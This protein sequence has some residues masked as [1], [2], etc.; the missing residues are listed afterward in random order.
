MTQRIALVAANFRKEVTSTVMWLSQFRV[1]MQCFKATPFAL[2]DELFLNVEQIIP[3]KDAEDF[4]IG[5]ADKAKDEVQGAETEARRH[6]VRHQFWS[7][8]IPA[9]NATAS[10][11]YGNISPSVT[12]W[13]SAGTGQRG[14]GLNFAATQSYGRAEL[15]IDRGDKAE[16]E[17]IFDRLH[18][19]RD[20]IEAAVG[21][22]LV[23]ERLDNR[24]ASRIKLERA[25]DVFDPTQWP[26]LI[27]F[28]V[29]AMVRLERG[30][31]PRL[32][33]AVAGARSSASSP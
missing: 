22:P 27:R 10:T 29:D 31:K 16:N 28:M 13:I 26:D 6:K 20:A 12:N 2:N 1:R 14:V 33:A 25:G 15:Y 32:A 19:E 4:I 5:L 3:V 9:M 23:W 21:V 8:L 11:L 30:L 17:A 18:A 7:E 24:R